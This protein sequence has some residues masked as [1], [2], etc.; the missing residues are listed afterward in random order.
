MSETAITYYIT[1]RGFGLTVY[2]DT[3]EITRRL[4]PTLA[5][6]TQIAIEN[7]KTTCRQFRVLHVDPDGTIA[8]LYASSD[9]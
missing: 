2:R 7:G 3:V 5:E 4:I 8:R 9:A 6:A 1:E